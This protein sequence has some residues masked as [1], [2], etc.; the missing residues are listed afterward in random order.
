MLTGLAELG[1]L[2]PN[3]ESC[4]PAY[5][6]L[7]IKVVKEGEE[8]RYGGIV[9]LDP[10]PKKFPYFRGGSNGKDVSVTSII[11]PKTKENENPWTK[12]IN[13]KVVNWLKDSQEEA[14]FGKILKSISSDGVNANIEVVEDLKKEY[15][16]S[17][18]KKKT[19]NDAERKRAPIMVSLCIE[20]D[21]KLI[22]PGDSEEFKEQHVKNKIELFSKSTGYGTCSVCGRVGEMYGNVLPAIGL[23][24]ATTDQGGFT[25][26]LNT[27]DAWKNSPV[28]PS[29]ADDIYHGYEYIKCHLT[30]RKGSETEIPYTMTIIPDAVTPESLNR[31]CNRVE[32]VGN[33]KLSG[34]VF[35]EDPLGDIADEMSIDS[36]SSQ[37]SINLLLYSTE[38]SA[39]RIASYINDV[40]PSRLKFV[41]DTAREIYTS[42]GEKLQF[43]GEESMKAVF[44]LKSSVASGPFIQRGTDASWVISF[45]SNFFIVEEKKTEKG[46][47]EAEKVV[48][49]LDDKF[50]DVMTGIFTN[51][52]H[53]PDLFPEYMKVI[54]S[55]F[56][57]VYK[58]KAH[59]LKALAIDI[60][61][62]RI[63]GEP[64]MDQVLL[65]DT[66]LS[67][68]ERFFAET[69]LTDKGEKAALVAG[70]LAGKTLMAQRTERDLN[71]GK[72]PF[73]QEFGDISMMEHWKLRNIVAKSVVK[74]RE[75]GYGKWDDIIA[76]EEIATK[77]TAEKTIDKTPKNRLGFY[78][79]AGVVLSE[80]IVPIRYGNENHADGN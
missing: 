43:L 71:P 51:L 65:E 9:S 73:W 75:Y 4:N 22:C 76:I 42:Q 10:N 58:V 35:A 21:G 34:I 17:L 16:E 77:L 39:V 54:R 2:K 61:M 46:K 20:K 45:L 55:D 66:V 67:K 80:S 52:Q 69:G 13:K 59:V 24:F 49:E 63:T 7:V 23:K 68:M 28:C 60:F 70:I 1:K 53:R 40:M 31:F 25:Y 79:I 74:L 64:I 44:G 72:E 48:R 12:T 11:P 56:Y 6:V 57:E 30:F 37:I 36:F 29:C 41:Y 47:K 33:E 19:E 8:Y 5:R 18:D 26:G 3:Q 15:L 32:S 78:F 27:K 14:E 62:S 38:N 50:F